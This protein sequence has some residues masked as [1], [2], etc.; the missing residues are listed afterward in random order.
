MHIEQSI[1]LIKLG[2]L[3][4]TKCLFWKVSARGRDANFKDRLSPK[5]TCHIVNNEAGRG[6]FII[7]I[8][9][10]SNCIPGENS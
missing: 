10:S 6:S 7:E 9:I 4:F 1:D 8:T 5:S 3:M 2:P